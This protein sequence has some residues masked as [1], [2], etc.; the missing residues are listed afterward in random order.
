MIFILLYWVLSLGAIGHFEMCKNYVITFVILSQYTVKF[1]IK[2][3]CLKERGKNGWCAAKCVSN[4]RDWSI[5]LRES[6][7]VAGVFPDSLR[8]P[9]K[10]RVSLHREVIK[11]RTVVRLRE[12]ETKRF[13]YR[14]RTKVSR[15]RINFENT[16]VYVENYYERVRSNDKMTIT[17]LYCAC[18][19]IRINYATRRMSVFK[20]MLLVSSK[21][22][23]MN[24][25]DDALLNGERIHVKQI[26]DIIQ[27]IPK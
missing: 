19:W 9:W 4:E 15:T 17:I 2:I 1:I 3:H 18:S 11:P 6:G 25:L 7:H 12:H 23:K 16:H 5:I 20:L 26:Y 21:C 8:N 22:S 10:C 14:W 13:T 24:R 27:L